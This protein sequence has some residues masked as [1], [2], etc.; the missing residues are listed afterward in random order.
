MKGSFLIAKIDYRPASPPPPPNSNFLG[1]VWCVKLKLMGLIVRDG[2]L[3]NRKYLHPNA[4][5]TLIKTLY[6]NY[7]LI[8][9]NNVILYK[10]IHGED[11]SL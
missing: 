6:V 3:T 4:S 8:I 9:K 7:K 5:N 10:W 11:F 2:E 1:T